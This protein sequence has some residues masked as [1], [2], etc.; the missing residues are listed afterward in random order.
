MASSRLPDK[1]LADIAGLPMVVRVA[2]RAAAK[3]CPARGG[4]GRRRAHP[5]SLPAHGV[6][7]LLTR[8]DH[9]SGSDRLAEACAQL[10]LDGDD[11][12][13]NVQG[14]EPLMDP[15][16]STPWRPC[17]PT[18]RCQHGHGRPCHRLASRLPTPTSS[19]W[20]WTP[21]TWRHYFSRA[22]IPWSS[23]QCGLAW[24]HGEAE[25][26]APVRSA[27]RLCAAAPRRHLQLPRRFSAAVSAAA[28]RAHR[29]C[30]G[31]GAAAGPVARPPHCRAYRRC[32]PWPRRGH[33]RRPGKSARYCWRC[34]AKP[35]EPRARG[36]A[37]AK[38][39][40]EPRPH[41]LSLPA[42]REHGIL[43]RTAPL[44]AVPHDF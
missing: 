2:Q 8:T 24:W 43:G 32:G 16:S 39:K 7:A 41:M 1:P 29:G 3:R 36:G 6:Q 11:I 20:C 10:G 42:T 17:C 5:A 13:V 9:A 21:A 27:C 25:A 18:P 4:G 44:P 38:R 26:P 31:T 15:R 19:R 14:D 12:V 22:P 33:P 35:T 23:D 28:P 40:P 37:R 30:R 34:R